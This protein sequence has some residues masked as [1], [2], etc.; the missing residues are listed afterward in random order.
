MR[1]LLLLATATVALSACGQKSDPA[2]SAGGQAVSGGGGA[3]NQ[4]WA[5]GS[6]TVFP[7]ATRVAETVGRTTGG[8]AA[9]VESLGTG[10]GFKLF[11]GGTGASFPDVAN[12][13]RAMKKSEWDACQAAGV[14]DIVEIKIGYDGIVIADAKNAPAFN[15]KLE[16]IYKALAAEVP[17]G[18]G[19]AA[20]TAATWSAVDPSLPNERI[21]V[22]GP[23]P[24]SGT[25]DAFVEIAMEKGAAKVAAMAALK[26]SDEN[27]F[28]EKAHTLRRDG[29]WV[30]AGENDNAIVQTLEKTPAA[31]GAFGYSFLDNN[32]DKVKAA[33]VD[34]VMPTAETISNGTY[35]IARS[36]Y[37]YVKKANIGVTPGLREFVSGFVSDAA[38]GKGGYLL[39]RGLIPLPAAEHAAQKAV[40]QALT[41][42]AAP[43]S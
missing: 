33:A 18:S 5:A 41:P 22:Y 2:A 14:T 9:K 38:T 20:N 36:L 30:D 43:K 11:C 16:H 15:L 34:G 37:I 26:A 24:T 28:K 13:S 40:V 1:A 10:G 19:F 27:Q 21:L 7:F 17:A 6:S 29:A 12:A 23:P 25:R 42:M 4:V 8:A 39:Q 32:R 3:R 31:V 35:P